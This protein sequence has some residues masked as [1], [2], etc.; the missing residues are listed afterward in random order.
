V[1]NSHNV[2]FVLCVSGS[3]AAINQSLHHHHSSS[4]SYLY[5]THNLQPPH[6]PAQLST[7]SA[8]LTLSVYRDWGGVRVRP[9]LA[10][11]TEA[12]S[13]PHPPPQ[14]IALLAILQELW[15]KT[16]STSHTLL[17]Q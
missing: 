5:I 2:C 9:G 14:S 13:S 8:R 1:S 4:P 15:K 12:T 3:H 11:T 17:A 10:S 16:L 7:V 6:P